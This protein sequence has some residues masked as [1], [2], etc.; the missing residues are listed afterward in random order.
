MLYYLLMVALTASA[1]VAL[2]PA[3]YSQFA[4]IKYC[5]YVN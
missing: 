3:V 1:K 2:L 5:G 4:T